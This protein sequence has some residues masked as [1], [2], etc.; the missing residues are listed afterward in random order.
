MYHWLRVVCVRFR[1]TS[2]LIF[3]VIYIDIKEETINLTDTELHFKGKSE[4]KDYEINIAF[5]EDVDSGEG[6]TYKVLPRSVQF[7]VMKKEQEGDFWPRLLKDKAL[8]KNQVKIDWDRY[9]DDDEEEE[10]GGFDMSAMQGGMGMGG[11]MPGMPPG[12]MPPGMG[13]MPGMGGAGGMPGMGG[14]DMEALV[15]CVD[16]W[17][18]SDKWHI[19]SQN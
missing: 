12:G 2:S 7:H 16:C 13:G 8:E 17:G 14:M 5:F 1:W 19:S 6:S 3:P 18:V 11:G 15:R 4:K 9:V 10:A